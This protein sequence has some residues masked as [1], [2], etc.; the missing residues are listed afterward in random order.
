MQPNVKKVAAI[1]DLSGFGRT[2]LT[3]IIPTLSTMGVQVC[4]VPTAILS[5]HSGGFTDYSFHDLTDSMQSHLKH[6]K[7]LH[8]SFDAIY[9]GFLG[10]PKQVD[11]VLEII[12]DFGSS[13][14]NGANSLSS[15]QA[16]VVVDPVMGDSGKL[17]NSISPKMIPQMRR[18][19]TKADIIVPNITEASF[20]LDRPT[21]KKFT[22][23]EIKGYLKALSKMGPETVVITSVLDVDTPG[24]LC[25]AAYQKDTDSYWKVSTE[26]LPVMYPGT[27]DIFASVMIGSLLKGE[28][29]PVSID[30]AVHF[31][32]QCIN[33]SRGYDYPSRNGVLL[34]RELYFLREPWA[35]SSYEKI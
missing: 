9:S 32:S 33:A 20:L 11:I 34:E 6:W 28:S 27:G 2:S 18:L 35:I 7:K 15:A 23:N 3:V 13:K 25:T 5:T 17:Y 30:R 22:N 4:P 14:K 31:I 10:S 8:L 21:P 16:L 1:H 29:L 26:H 12:N 19:I 24:V